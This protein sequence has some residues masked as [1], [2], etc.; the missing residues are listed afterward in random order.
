MSAGRFGRIKKNIGL[1]TSELSGCIHHPISHIIQFQMEGD[2]DGG[3]RNPFLHIKH[4]VILLNC[5]YHDWE[6][7]ETRLSATQ[8]PKSGML[9]SFGR[10][11]TNL[12]QNSGYHRHTQT[13]ASFYN[14]FSV[15]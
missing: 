7:W 1:L 10:P 4:T 14:G 12:L 5:H 8:G 3:M 13:A 15:M 2:P 6:I 9:A 11:V